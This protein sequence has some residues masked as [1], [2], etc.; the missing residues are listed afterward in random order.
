MS[1]LPHH[2]LD[3]NLARLEKQ[4]ELD[5]HNA[6]LLLEHAA[7]CLSRAAFHGGGERWFERA[8]QQVRTALQSGPGQTGHA[9]GLVI[10]AASQLGAD[11]SRGSSSRRLELARKLLDDALGLEPELPLGHYVLG[12]WYQA[13]ARTMSGSSGALLAPEKASPVPSA[14]GTAASSTPAAPPMSSR[15]RHQAAAIRATET[16]CRLAPDAWEPHALLATLL[17][18]RCSEQG[19]PTRAPR[20]LE[21]SQFHTVR[22]LELGPGSDQEPGLWFHL[23]VTC[24]YAAAPPPAPLRDPS[25]PAPQRGPL[26]AAG[27]LFTRLLDD[28]KYRERAQYYLGVVNYQVGRYKNA[29]LYLRQHLDHASEPNARVH[30]RI[31]MAYLKL[32]ELA[33]ARDA[34]SRALSLDPSDVA[35]RWTLGSAFAADGQEEEA[36]RI[37]RAILQDVPDHQGAF[38]ELVALREAKGDLTWLQSALRSEV[39]GYDRLPVMME[40]EQG[41]VHPRATTRERIGVLTAALCS[42]DP[43]GA[44]PAVLEAIDLTTDERLRF[45]LWEAALDQVCALKSQALREQLAQPGSLFSAKAGREVLALARSLPED[46][47][48]AALQIDEEDLRRAAVDRHGPARDVAAHRRAIDAER[49]QARAWQALL[50]LAIAS[51]GNQKSRNLLNLWAS[52]ADDDLA[53]AAR[54]AL[55]MLGDDEAREALHKRARARG[56]ANLVDAMVAQVS[57]P[58]GAAPFAVRPLAPGEDRACSACHRR[59]AD[60]GHMMVGLNAAICDLCLAEVARRRRELETEDPAVVCA[61]SGRGR[62]STQ[63]MYVYE[64]VPLCREVLDQ[65]LGWLERETVERFL[66]SL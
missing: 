13:A 4:L 28:T 55:V 38:G 14:G 47:L 57:A 24:T 8:H 22:A 5:P 10:A 45:Q 27:K 49:R 30:A 41:V 19:G 9:Q 39:K 17:W 25:G 53:D 18:E 61:L 43:Q 44:V 40:R 52:E 37:F 51:H 56:A 29:V 32:G 46:L 21:R 31:A 1:L 11:S 35:A 12:L 23:A 48:M 7:T 60:V 66:G 58:T 6:A 2:K 54:A 20:L 62:E 64:G 33:K 63:A 42:A 26:E 50:L 16:A 59:P 3:W 65:G 36:Q 15:A 34:A